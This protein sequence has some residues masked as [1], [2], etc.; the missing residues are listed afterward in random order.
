MVS[1]AAKREAVGWLTQDFPASQRRACRVLS[2]SLA[3][4]RYRSRRGDGGLIRQRL[5]SL[6]EERPRFG[7]RRLHVMLRREG[8]EVNHKRTYRLYRLETPEN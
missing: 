3:T 1:P 4:Y 5:L 8:F 7:Y 2:L 6:A